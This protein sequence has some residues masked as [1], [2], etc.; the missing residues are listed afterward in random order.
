MRNLSHLRVSTRARHC[1][2][3]TGL[4]E[5]CHG[6]GHRQSSKQ[7]CQLPRSGP[8]SESLSG[9]QTV[10]RNAVSH[11]C[12]ASTRHSGSDE[13]TQLRYHANFASGA[14]V[15]GLAWS[16]MTCGADWGRADVA[17]EGGSRT[18]PGGSGPGLTAGYPAVDED[19]KSMGRW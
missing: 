12:P 10:L 16:Q 7:P 17:A 9:A 2:G 18:G 1:R 15:R 3:G 5:F 4:P 11:P 13:A 8:P 19:R 14:A 6:P